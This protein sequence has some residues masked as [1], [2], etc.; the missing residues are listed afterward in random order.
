MPSQTGNNHP[1]PHD[2]GVSCRGAKQQD[3]ALR[4]GTDGLMKTRC[5]HLD[6]IVELPQA[7][8]VL[9]K[10][11]LW[12]L[13]AAS[14]E[15]SSALVDLGTVMSF[16]VAACFRGSASLLSADMQKWNDRPHARLVPFGHVALSPVGSKYISSRC[17]RGKWWFALTLH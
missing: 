15:R 1:R 10:T 2:I 4:E 16:Q 13:A 12:N 3:R 5:S 6:G 17:G 8:L 11:L 7:V 9:I 14:T